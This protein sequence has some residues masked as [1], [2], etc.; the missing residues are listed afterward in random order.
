MTWILF[1]T[2]IA[3]AIGIGIV[4]WTMAP[5]RKPRAKPPAADEKAGNGGVS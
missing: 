2:L 4:W 5:R 1:E 3:L